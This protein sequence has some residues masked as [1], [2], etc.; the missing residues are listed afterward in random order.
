[1]GGHEEIMF[2]PGE[3]RRIL[4]N[5]AAQA[6]YSLKLGTFTVRG[7]EQRGSQEN[8]QCWKITRSRFMEFIKH[9]GREKQ[10]LQSCRVNALEKQTTIR[11]MIER[12][13]KKWEQE[14]MQAKLRGPDFMKTEDEDD[15]MDPSVFRSAYN[16]CKCY[17]SVRNALNLTG[18]SFFDKLDPYATVQFEGSKQKFTTS[19]LQDAGADPCWDCEGVLIYNGATSMEVKVYDYDR[20]SQHD[21]IASAKIEVEEFCRGLEG[22][23]RLNLPAGKKKKSIKQMMIVL[24]I[25]WDS[26]PEQN[27]FNSTSKSS[28]A[29]ST[30]EQTISSGMSRTR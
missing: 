28:A 18:G 21:L 16:G 27:A 29:M 11:Q 7:A 23:I 26:T 25:M 2:K 20:Y 22:M 1:M 3:F 30:K 9:C 15:V 24:G 13:I 10:F 12:L 4:E 6:D 8:I 5:A 14:M 17:I 19:V